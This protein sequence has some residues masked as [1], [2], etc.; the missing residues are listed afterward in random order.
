MDC[1]NTGVLEYWITDFPMHYS[2]TLPLDYCDLFYI[3]TE[4]AFFNGL[5]FLKPW[6]HMSLLDSY[7][8]KSENL[9]L[10]LYAANHG[11]KKRY[12]PRR[13]AR[14]ERPLFISP[15]LGALCAFAGDTSSEFFSRQDAKHA[16]AP[17]HPTI[18]S[19]RPPTLISPNLAP[20]A[21]L[22]ETLLRNSF[23]AK[24]PSSP[25]PLRLTNFSSRPLPRFLRTWR[26]LRL[27]AS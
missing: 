18:F 2:A 20:F 16:K 1:W 23:P 27:C 15:N 24:T 9:S 4:F 22:R 19:S 14:K 10:T 3:V 26:T 13:Q 8:P 5:N 12:R 6:T 17:H 11:D 21:P 7:T 25:R